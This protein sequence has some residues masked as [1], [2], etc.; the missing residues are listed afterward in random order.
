MT[1]SVDQRKKAK[2]REARADMAHRKKVAREQI[3]NA[4][5]MDKMAA[6]MR[7]MMRG[8]QKGKQHG[9]RMD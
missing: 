6:M 2:L 4:P 9:R 5:I 3:E 7:K 1:D 8:R